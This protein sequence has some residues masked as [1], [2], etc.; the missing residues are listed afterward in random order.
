MTPAERLA[1]EAFLLA[2]YEHIAKA[3][4]TTHEAISAFFKNYLVI[5]GLP[6]AAIPIVA[7]FLSD[8]GVVA[9]PSKYASLPY[10]AGLIV[11]VVGFCMMMHI[12]NLRHDALLYAKTVNGI[13]N[14]FYSVAALPPADEATFRVLPRTL[15]KPR[16]S[17]LSF[18][19]TVIAFGIL[20]GA[21][22]AIGAFLLCNGNGAGPSVGVDLALKIIG[23]SV[24]AHICV[25]WVGSRITERRHA[26]LVR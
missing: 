17:Q 25:F 7:R 11:A 15:S 8:K 12:L 1:F 20:N 24:I 3:H 2:E 21:Y 13:R 10:I 6:L 14:F 19:P 26:R 22:P 18:L 16:Y 9:I 5:V 4:F 23:L